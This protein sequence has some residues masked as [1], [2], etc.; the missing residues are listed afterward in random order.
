MRVDTK[1]TFCPNCQ[2]LVMGRAQSADDTIKV[3]CPRCNEVIWLWDG[4]KWLQLRK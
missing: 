1:K 3:S 2:K 4:T